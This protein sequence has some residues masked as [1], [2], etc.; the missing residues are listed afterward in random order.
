M[1]LYIDGALC[2]GCSS[3][4]YGGIRLATTGFITSMDQSASGGTIS[5]DEVHIVPRALGASEVSD[6]YNGIEK[7]HMSRTYQDGLG[8]STRSVV[9]DMF[10]TK[11]TTVATLGWN[12][13]PVYSYLPSGQY[14]TFAYDFLGRNLVAQSPGD[15]TIS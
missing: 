14:S 1:A 10:G 4:A 9:M 13:K 2:G 3:T 5:V 8:R 7:S 6:L 11:I 15:S 12:D